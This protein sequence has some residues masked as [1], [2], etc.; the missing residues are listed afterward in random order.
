[1]NKKISAAR[2]PTQLVCVWRPTGDPRMP[3]VCTWVQE[4]KAKLRPE[5][6][7][8]SNEAEEERLCA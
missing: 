5:S 2:R 4:E 7:E 6:S 3:L 8:S 1:M